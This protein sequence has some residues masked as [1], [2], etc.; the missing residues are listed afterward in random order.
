MRQKI[1]HYIGQLSDVN[2]LVGRVDSQLFWKIGLWFSGLVFCMAI[3]LTLEVGGFVSI[4]SRHMA[5]Q[6]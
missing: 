4:F 1:R 5:L 2:I 6:S 3:R